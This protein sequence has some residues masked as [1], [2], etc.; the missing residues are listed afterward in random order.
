MK[1]HWSVLTLRTQQRLLRTR[2]SLYFVAQFVLL[3]SEAYLEC[4]D[5]LS[6]VLLLYGQGQYS[7]HSIKEPEKQPLVA[8]IILNFSNK[9]ALI[10][11]LEII[12][13]PNYSVHQFFKEVLFSKEICLVF[14]QK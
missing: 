7:R 5:A 12:F 2:I 9:Q 1:K 4:S 6:F 3:T 10:M 8:V 14:Y 13:T 11:F